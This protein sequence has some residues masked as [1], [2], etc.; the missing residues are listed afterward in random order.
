VLLNTEQATLSLQLIVTSA[1]L[2]YG[3]APG[4]Y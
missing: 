3:K 1:N 2:G 4:L